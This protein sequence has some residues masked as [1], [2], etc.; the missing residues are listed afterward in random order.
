MGF[1]SK[2]TPIFA[3]VVG[4]TLTISLTL[5]IYQSELE[6]KTLEN[7][8]E[9]ELIFS[10]LNDRLNDYLLILYA[11]RGF[12]SGVGF[13]NIDSEKWN[14]FTEPIN[15]NNKF[16]D[17]ITI[18]LIEIVD[19]KDAHD[20]ENSMKKEFDFFQIKPRTTDIHHVLKYVSP[21]TDKLQFLIGFD[22]YSEPNRRQCDLDSISTNSPQFS[23]VIFLNQDTNPSFASLICL[24]IFLND[25]SSFENPIGL[26]TLAFRFENIFLGLL[27]SDHV[28]TFYNS[29]SEKIFSIPQYDGPLYFDNTYTL[30][31]DK[32]QFTVE[33]ASKSSLEFPFVSI[34][35]LFVG[36]S[37]SVVLSII[38]KKYF[39]KIQRNESLRIAQLR[40]VTQKRIESE[41]L[42]S[43][44][45][46]KDE[47]TTIMTHESKNQ[48]FPILVECNMFRDPEFRKNLT[49]EQIKMIENIETNTR[50]IKS[51]IEDMLT[52]QKLDLNSQTSPK[53]TFDS[54]E[55][56]QEL[57]QQFGPLCDEKNITFSISCKKFKI[58][59]SKYNLIQILRN[60]ITNSIDFTPQNGQIT[61]SIVD[62]DPYWKFSVKDNGAGITEDVQKKLFRD[63]ISYND[64][65]RKFGGN[66]LGLVFCK[67]VVDSLGGKIW[68][69]S[70]VDVGTEII[71][72]IPKETI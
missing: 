69:E 59:S 8:D 31:L 32:K 10:T 16:N 57:N 50:L 35:V 62:D 68:V 52:V 46:K 41:H 44:Q 14:S 3:L 66:G 22:N 54:E 30:D 19:E 51:Q 26:V 25:D 6:I 17:E 33:I 9:S 12:V 18:S 27:D 49:I 47:F 13:E 2:Y 20:F 23:D 24:P 60:L 53:V 45:K 5:F 48:I 11:S 58:H 72:T 42:Q 55:F 65:P 63:F 36:L 7:L 71:F 61:V 67:K 28:V 34:I 21:F 40:E 1:D 70:K 56:V 29:D 15:F 39:D 43:E 37:M 64:T 38:L 4:F